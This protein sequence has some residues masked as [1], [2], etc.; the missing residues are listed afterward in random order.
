MDIIN[1]SEHRPHEV[2][3]LMCANCYKRWIGVYPETELLKNMVCKSCNTR[4]AIIKTGQTIFE[5]RAD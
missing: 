1:I 3:E 2:A 5:A 4:G